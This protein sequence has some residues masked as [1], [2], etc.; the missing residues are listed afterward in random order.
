MSNHTISN[1][2]ISN[3]TILNHTILN[4]TMSNNIISI[5][6]CQIIKYRSCNAKSYNVNNT[7]SIIQ[8]EQYINVDHTMSN[9]KN[10][11]SMS[12]CTMSN[13][14]RSIYNKGRFIQN[15]SYNAELY[16]VEI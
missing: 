14:K 1:H 12:N 2:I 10:N 5:V 13:H 6:Q 7:M 9:H 15:K 3:H 16:H 11:Y 4:H 8:C